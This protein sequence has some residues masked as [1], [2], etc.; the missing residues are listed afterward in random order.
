MHRID[1]FFGRQKI[2][3]ILVTLASFSRSQQHFKMSNFDQNSFPGH[4]LM[5]RMVNSS[6]TQGFPLEFYF[7]GLKSRLT[8]IQGDI[9]GDFRGHS[10][11]T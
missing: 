1:T 2:D 6:Q 3:W 4:Y 8:L 5:N 11:D 9:S 10:Y 7:R